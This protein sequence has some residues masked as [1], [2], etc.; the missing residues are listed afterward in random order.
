[1]SDKYTYENAWRDLKWN[2]E[3]GTHIRTKKSLLE[4]MERIEKK[5]DNTLP[6]FGESS[7]RRD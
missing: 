5:V 1:M 2:I 6:S 4:A 7:A 3:D